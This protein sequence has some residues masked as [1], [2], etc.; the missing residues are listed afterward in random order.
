[1]LHC[2]YYEDGHWKLE[3]ICSELEEDCHQQKIEWKFLDQGFLNVFQE[4]KEIK[5]GKKQKE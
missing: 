3:K 4:Y 2:N 1:M 5:K